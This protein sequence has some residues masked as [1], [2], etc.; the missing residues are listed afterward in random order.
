MI[1]TTWTETPTVELPKD[2][3]VYALTGKDGMRSRPM[4][5]NGQE[6]ALG[7]HDELPALE[8]KA[9]PAGRLEVAPGSCVF[10]VL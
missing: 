5:L 1:N 10:I 8:G 7:E 9:V 4:C 2:A 6:L 3:A